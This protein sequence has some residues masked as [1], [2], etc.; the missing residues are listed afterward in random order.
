MEGA[1]DPADAC[2]HTSVQAELPDAL[3]L[4]MEPNAAP[5]P[6]KALTPI[7]P[8]DHSQ[9]FSSWL[10]QG[11]GSLNV[12]QL[13]FIYEVSR[14]IFL[15]TVLNDCFWLAAVQMEAPTIYV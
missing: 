8:G 1:G 11:T 4:D 10:W 9:M 3:W 15:Y 13:R 14:H 5:K 6:I 7:S 2:I 12:K